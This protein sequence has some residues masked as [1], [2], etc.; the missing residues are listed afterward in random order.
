MN[1]YFK[2]NFTAFLL[3]FSVQVVA[4]QTVLITYE[5]HK[6]QAMLVKKILKRDVFLPEQLIK[7]KFQR[8]PCEKSEAA[9]VQICVKDNKAIEFAHFNQE[10]VQRSLSVFWEGKI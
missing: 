2:A 9:I 5:S 3:F 4:R 1:L 6:S 8:I 7:I 10:V